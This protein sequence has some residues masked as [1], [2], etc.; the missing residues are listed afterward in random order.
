MSELNI[1]EIGNDL[2]RAIRVA[3]GEFNIK[4]GDSIWGKGI[5]MGLGVGLMLVWELRK[6]ANCMRK[7]DKKI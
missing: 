4:A 1:K 3:D 7:D 2:S 6:I 5:V